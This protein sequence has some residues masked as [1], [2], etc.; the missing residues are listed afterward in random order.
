M[1][2]RQERIKATVIDIAGSVAEAIVLGTNLLRTRLKE[3]G[4]TRAQAQRFVSAECLIEC[5]LFEWFLYDAMIMVEFGRRGEDIRKALAGRVLIELC[6][7][8]LEMDSL[9]DFEGRWLARFGEYAAAAAAGESL[10][11]LGSV[12]CIRIFGQAGASERG[13][14]LLA[15]QA[16]ARL[17]SLRGL[18]KTYAVVQMSPALPE[19]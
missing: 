3:E 1:W 15:R 12:A 17:A 11:P 16:H 4:V 13:I 2:H 6:R 19:C 18:G 8:G 14:M 10:Q 9:A 7:G 5:T